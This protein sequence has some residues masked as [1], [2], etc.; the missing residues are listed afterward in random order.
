M[1][2]RGR[3]FEAAFASVFGRGA[4]SE[5]VRTTELP[6]DPQ[7]Q[8]F[9]ERFE[10]GGALPFHALTVEQARRAIEEQTRTFG[11]PQAVA[12]VED[13]EIPGPAGPLAV[14][15]YIPSH[16]ASLPALVYF[17]GGGWVIGN[18][19]THDAVCRAL[20]NSARC[21]TVAVDYRLAPEHR[22]PAALEDCYAATSWV[23]TN[24]Q[25]LGVDATRLAVGGDSAGGN[26]AAAVALMARERGAPAL[27]F[28]LLVY[29][30]TDDAMDTPS[31]RAFAEGFFLTRSDMEWFWNH[32][33]PDPSDRESC[34]ACPAKATDLSGLP[35]AMIITAEFDPLR[36]E[37]ERYAERLKAAGVPVT[38]KRYPGMV[39]GFFRLS[40]IIDQGKT[41]L[42]EAGAAL[43]A[44]LRS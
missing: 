44:A 11:S 33:A 16:E 40:H 37:G 39:H 28:Q 10:T 34:F 20:S 27:A 36:D 32:Y 22:F 42:A 17:H 9:L 14:R 21:L 43:R 4:A 38:L 31:H 15:I 1:V 3:G 30:V 8:A 29:P 41:A 2:P 7:A 23:A 35:P 6:L 19:N 12:R 25:R 26:L 18:L 24:A 13:R 5:A